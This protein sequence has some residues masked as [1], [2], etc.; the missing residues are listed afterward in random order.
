[1]TSKRP[2]CGRI[3]LLQN[4][5]RR[6]GVAHFADLGLDLGGHCRIFLGADYATMKLASFFISSVPMPREVTAAVPM[7]VAVNLVANC[8]DAVSD[9]GPHAILPRID[10]E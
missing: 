9:V 4:T 8:H 1:M 6:E 7:A 3:A 10:A 2:S 5:R